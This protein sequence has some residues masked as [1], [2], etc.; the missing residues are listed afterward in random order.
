M[1]LGKWFKRTGKRDQIFLTSKFG[2]AKGFADPTVIDSSREYCKKSCQESLDRLGT[3]YI[4]LY[5]MHRANPATPIEDTMR[6]LAEL[7]R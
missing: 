1:L 2:F 3:D 4:D 5:Y 7:K 6:G